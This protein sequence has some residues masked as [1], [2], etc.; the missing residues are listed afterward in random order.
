MVWYQ[1]MIAKYNRFECRCY[2]KIH[3]FVCGN[4]L[5]MKKSNWMQYKLNKN[6]YFSAP[7]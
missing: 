3:N 6:K 4:E 2:R 1:N 5:Q 7:L